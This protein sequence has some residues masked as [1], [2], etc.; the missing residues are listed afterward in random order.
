MNALNKGYYVITVLSIVFMFVSVY[1][2]LE[3]LMFFWAGTV[4][5]LDQSGL[6]LHH[7]VLHVR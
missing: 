6:C 3:D 7:A 5:I 1:Y 4:G 2:L